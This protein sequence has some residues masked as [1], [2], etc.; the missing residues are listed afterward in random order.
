VWEEITEDTRCGLRSLRRDVRLAV[1]VMTIVGLG[2]GACVTVFSVARAILLRPLP[3][4]D[5]GR[6]VWISNGDF[7]PG[8]RLSEI[9][10]QVA[11]LVGLRDEA[12]QLVDVGGYHLFDGDGDHTF[13]SGGDPERVTRLRVTG[14]LF[15]VL[16]VE[17]V[18]GRTF[19][20]EEVWDDGPSAVL[21]TWGFYVRRFAGDASI[22]GQAVNVDGA[23]ATVI[24]V[25]P[26]S[27]DFTSI[28]APGRRIDYVAPFPLSPRSNRS[29]NTLGLI[30]R[31]AP[32]A[33]PE[34]AT[35]EAAAIASRVEADRLNGFN[36]V[37]RPL[38]EHVS[39][40]FR[41]ALQ[42][43][44]GAVLLVLL[45]VCANLSNLLLA[46]SAAREREMA[47]RAAIGAPRRR[48][49]RQML[50]ESTILAGGGSLIGIAVAYL[51]TAF[52]AGLD[53][54]IP[55]LDGARVDGAA[56]AVAVLAALVVGLSSGVA[57]A[58]RGTDVRLHESLKDSAR[59]SSAG[60]RQG[61]LR[62][63]LVVVEV[64][65]A[66][67]LMIASTLF[68]RSLFEV[69]DVDLGYQADRTVAIRVDPTARFP[70]D[71]TRVAY[72]AEVLDRVRTLPGVEAAG[73]S[74]V[75]PMEF[76]R[77]WNASRPD[78]PP[79]DAVYPFVRMVSEGYVDA[80]GLTLVSGRDLS[81]TDGPDAPL[82]ALVNERLADLIWP[83]TS[84]LGERLRSSGRDYTVVG[85]VRNTRQLSVEQAPGPE[86]FFSIR[87]SGDQ[88]AVHLLLRGAQSPDGLVA[89][90]RPRLRAIAPGLPLDQVVAIRD[91]V[92]ASIAPRR[93]LVGLLVVFSVFALVLASLGIYGVI[94]YGVTQRRREIGIHIALGASSGDV[95]GRI[96][97]ETLTLAAL[98]LGTGVILAGA[99]GRLLTSLLFGVTALD[100][101]TYLGV[102]ALLGA[103]AAVAGFLP[104]RRAA[105]ANP[106][107]T[108]DG[109]MQG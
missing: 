17:P 26:P 33:A 35:A 88:S 54:H 91:V 13:V 87:Q 50:V 4:A 101:T 102:V 55:L 32:G 85:V 80:M 63:A 83:G 82:A 89:E 59:G 92:D 78:A 107:A 6:L 49:V 68:V 41:T 64:A 42:V 5:P 60:R 1:F 65:L 93:F 76:N 24:G 74:D 56:M 51:S 100:P 8:Q 28:F 75:L 38:R 77:T 46:K 62:R 48:L 90:A 71:E 95:Q 104:A 25:L 105:R 16:G 39:G 30:G 20:A 98:G 40:R 27:F 14:N 21:L 29:G 81:S 43:L 36:P 72:Y 57:P 18:L 109:D 58:L 7:G 31:L 52:L 34:S 22:L 12:E 94:S 37:I 84:P 99:G 66:C 108:L 15:D 73:L 86:V 106:L 23:P 103:V 53:L 9:S 19:S 61:V 79:E 3:F 67:T 69:L 2:V 10:V 45:I 97:R 44:T 96:L 11:Y 47:I 70:S